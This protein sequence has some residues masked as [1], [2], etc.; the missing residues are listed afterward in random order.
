MARVEMAPEIADDFDRLL[1]FQVQ[2][3]SVDASGRIM[4]I[5][6]AIDVLAL[7]P[8]IGRAVAGGKR[9]L[10]VGRKGHGYV[11]LYQYLVPVDAVLVL[12]VRSQREAAYARP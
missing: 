11:V 5:I 1:S 6:H 8:L 10:T 12:A 2:H 4:E 7:N 9:E 3:G